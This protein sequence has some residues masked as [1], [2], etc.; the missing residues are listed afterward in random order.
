MD[1]QADTIC[2]GKGWVPEHFTG[3]TVNVDGFH[4]NLPSI[5]DVP[6]GTASTAY[7]HPNGNTYI[8]TAAEG[9][10]FFDSMDHSLIPPAQLW[11]NNI[12]CD[13]RPKQ[14]APD[15]IFGIHDAHQDLHIPFQLHG[16]I[17][18]LPLRLPTEAELEQCPCIHLT[19]DAPWDPYHVR[20]QQQEQPSN[21]I[22]PTPITTCTIQTLTIS[23]S[24]VPYVLPPVRITGPPS[25][26]SS[27]PTNG[28]PVWR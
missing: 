19:N 25:P 15:S 27:W 9:L 7:D 24:T 8:L 22:N 26:L 6:I 4:D 21:H 10:C 18:Y 23:P 17:S 5:K 11:D 12:L 14:Y 3:Q 20:F 16:C 1:S 13:I 28:G 2:F